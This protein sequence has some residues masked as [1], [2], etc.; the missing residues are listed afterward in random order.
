MTTNYGGATVNELDDSRISWL[1]SAW[2]ESFSRTP[3]WNEEEDFDFVFQDFNGP[4]GVLLMQL[5]KPH[6]YT[7]DL[8]SIEV[9]QEFQVSVVTHAS[10]YNRAALEVSAKGASLEHRPARS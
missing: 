1:S 7:V 6:T 4:D 10:S 8:S 2:N 3:L 9:G 5:R